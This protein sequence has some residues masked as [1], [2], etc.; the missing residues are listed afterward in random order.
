MTEEER[1]RLVAKVDNLEDDFSGYC[2][3]LREHPDFLRHGNTVY[4]AYVPCHTKDE[5]LMLVRQLPAKLVEK[6]GQHICATYTLSS[7]VTIQV[8][9]AADAASSLDLDI[10]AMIKDK[11][12][13]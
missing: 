4:T 5:F 8:Y 11:R 10:A 6:N 12:G 13:E 9:V 3:F 7:T 2:Q 1:D